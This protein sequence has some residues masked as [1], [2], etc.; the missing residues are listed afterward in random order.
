MYLPP[1][2]AASISG[3]VIPSPNEN[4]VLPLP[5]PSVLRDSW[6]WFQLPPWPCKSDS[7]I[8]VIKNLV[9]AAYYVQNI[10]TALQAMPNKFNPLAP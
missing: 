10:S 8:F 4:T 3:P 9:W 5:N 1:L 7:A 2:A 6:D